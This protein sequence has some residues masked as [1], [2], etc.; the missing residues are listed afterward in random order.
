MVSRTA[1]WGPD[2]EFLGIYVLQALYESCPEAFEIT[3]KYAC[4]NWASI[5]CSARVDRKILSPVTECDWSRCDK[6][7]PEEIQKMDVIYAL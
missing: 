3:P 6:I 5:V 7:S 2:R 4:D 1:A